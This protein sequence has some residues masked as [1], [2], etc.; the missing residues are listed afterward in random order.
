MYAVS[1]VRGRSEAKELA[2]LLAESLGTSEDAKGR[3]KEQGSP[4][5]RPGKSRRS[6]GYGIG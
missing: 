4:Q 5:V 1:W 2:K 6:G 3:R